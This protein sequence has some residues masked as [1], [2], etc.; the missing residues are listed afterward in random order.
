MFYTLVN[1]SYDI[2]NPKHIICY[3]GLP[4]YYPNQFLSEKGLNSNETRD[5][6][7]K[8]LVRFFNYIED[9]YNISDFRNVQNEFAIRDFMHSIIYK[10]IK[11][12][13]G[14][15]KLLYNEETLLTPSTATSYMKRIQ[16]FYICLEKPLLGLIDFDDD[17]IK[18]LLTNKDKKAIRQKTKYKK[19]WGYLNLSDLN[20]HSNTKWKDKYK[21]KKSFTKEEIDCIA[22]NLKNISQ[23]DFCIFL[24]CLETGARISEVTTGLMSNF[25]KNNAG[26]WTFGITNS[27]NQKRY[28]AIPVYLAKLINN[29]IT[30]ERKEITSNKSNYKYLFVSTKGRNKGSKIGY[31]TFRTKLKTAG[32]LGGIDSSSILTHLARGTKATTMIAQGKTQEQARI[33]LGNKV[34]INPYID[35]SNPDLITY[36]SEALYYVEEK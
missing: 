19:I 4:L 1:I 22:G 28:V 18:S 36:S 14:K 21:K 9:E 16:N 26:I 7:A 11:T 33:A 17:Y 25:K 12:N 24:V 35:Y 15:T 13:D 5:A 10:C 27:K 23:R 30:T 20:L 2:E 8:I 29:Y 31:N 32:K 34:T 3:K 6:Y